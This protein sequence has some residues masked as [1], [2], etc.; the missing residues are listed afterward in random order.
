VIFAIAMSIMI[1]AVVPAGHV[2][3]LA[4]VILGGSGALLLYVLF[5]KAL[6]VGELDDLSHTVRA[7]LRR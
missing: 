2:A 4:T 1:G 3:A 5:A 7:R 6:G